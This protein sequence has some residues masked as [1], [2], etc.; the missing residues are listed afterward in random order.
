MGTSTLDTPELISSSNRV[1]HFALPDVK[2]ITDIR[3]YMAES[4][5]FN[6]DID[7]LS[8]HIMKQEQQCQDIIKLLKENV[9]VKMNA[10]R[11][12]KE[13]MLELQRHLNLPN[14]QEIYDKTSKILVKFS[15]E[16]EM[17]EYDIPDA[18][19]RYSIKMSSLYAEI[20]SCDS[21]VDY[22][23]YLA[24][25]AKINK[26]YVQDWYNREKLVKSK[27]SKLKVGDGK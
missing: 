22:V 11:N 16:T 26:E 10:L 6:G 9:D 4:K 8:A 27:T 21:D 25:I 7:K 23:S 15:D 3:K 1:N 24:S 14:A 2:R 5:H 19:A 20:L 17:N 18:L 12:V 13:D